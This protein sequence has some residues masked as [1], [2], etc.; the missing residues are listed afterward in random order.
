[1]LEEGVSEDGVGWWDVPA[2]AVAFCAG[3]IANHDPLP[4]RDGM[5]RFGKKRAGRLLDGQE[6][7]QMPVAP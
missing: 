3:F 4:Y 2:K 5:V 1:M 7:N 6:R